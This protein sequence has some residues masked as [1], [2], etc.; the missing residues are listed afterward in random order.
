MTSF[1]FN[2]RAN[3]IFADGYLDRDG[4]PVRDTFV[5]KLRTR[6]VGAAGLCWSKSQN[7]A[8]AASLSSAEMDAIMSDADHPHVQVEFD[9]GFF[10]GDYTGVGDHAYIP[11]ALVDLLDGDV[12]AAFAKL[13]RIDAVH[14][15]RYV[16]DQRFD[17]YGDPLGVLELA[18]ETSS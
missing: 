14:I 4:A 18:A 10:G 6:M 12:G 11:E 17:A 13:T 16:G 3:G 9:T 7:A 5:Y 8:L 2:I 15:V 1:H